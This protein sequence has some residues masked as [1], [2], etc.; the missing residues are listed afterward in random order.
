MALLVHSGTAALDLGVDFAMPEDDSVVSRAEAELMGIVFPE[1]VEYEVRGRFYP[2]I[3]AL[4]T[5]TEDWIYEN[6]L[7]HPKS[8][9]LS[10]WRHGIVV[11]PGA[12]P[13]HLST[14]TSGIFIGPNVRGVTITGGT[15]GP[16]APPRPPAPMPVEER[17]MPIV[18]YRSWKFQQVY[19]LGWGKKGCL[20]PLNTGYGPWTGGVNTATCKY[21]QTHRPADEHCSCGFHVLTSLDQAE[22]WV[23]M[24]D[25]VIVGAVMGW[26]KVV[27]HG[28]E[29]W[30]A[31]FAK[32]IA[33]LDCKFSKLQSENTKVIA[34]TYN[35]EVKERS[36]LEAMV[37]E[38]GDPFPKPA[39]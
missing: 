36:Q 9:Y 16:Y 38:W 12:P 8:D 33:L 32:V 4:E 20:V 15:F 14:A 35:L 28:T 29:G 37:S 6:G 10:L 3:H 2:N 11:G 27:Q 31:E 21:G 30:R 17:E 39:A 1:P 24:A 13:V 34:K 5:T 7:Y 26:G 19:K 23:S 22:S 25:D 18:G